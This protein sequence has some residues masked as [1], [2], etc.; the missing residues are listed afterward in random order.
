MNIWI[1]SIPSLDHLPFHIRE[2]NLFTLKTSA[3]G[4]GVVI[5][6]FSACIDQKKLMNA[7]QTGKKKL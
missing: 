5:P 2:L 4:G 3:E 7:W 1:I 6:L